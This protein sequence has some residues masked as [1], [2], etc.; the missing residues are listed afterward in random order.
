MEEI[1]L[2]YLPKS[3]PD[4]KNADSKEMLDI[5]IPGSI[6]HPHLRIRKIE[7]KYEMTKKSPIKEGDS[8]HHLELTIPLTTEEYEE[9][10]T[11]PGKR[12]A[13]TR[14]YFQ[15]NSINYEIDIFKEELTGL[16][17]VDIEFNSLEEKSNFIAPD[18]LLVE[19]TQENFIAG[20][21]LCGKKYTDISTQLEQLGY[22]PLD[23]S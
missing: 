2:T 15:E 10:S 20:G 19:I 6:E 4:L 3:L 21:M 17:L 18:W 8:S 13:K 16:V 9:L 5:Y 14:Y 22:K 12:V 11:L 1:E 7:E 23:I